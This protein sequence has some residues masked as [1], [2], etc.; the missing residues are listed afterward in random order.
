IFPSIHRENLTEDRNL[1]SEVFGLEIGQLSGDS[2]AVGIEACEP[3]A[4]LRLL[5]AD[6]VQYRRCCGRHGGLQW[7][8]VDR[9]DQSCW[10]LTP[11]CGIFN[12]RMRRLTLLAADVICGSAPSAHAAS[13]GRATTQS[14]RRDA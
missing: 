8:Q 12:S 9:D 6:L 13:R 11:Q 4:D 2:C 14:V 7:F 1:A 3:L 5:R 10:R